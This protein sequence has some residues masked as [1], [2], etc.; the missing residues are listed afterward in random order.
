[1]MN[2]TEWL[3]LPLL[4]R[5]WRVLTCNHIKFFEDHIRVG[6]VV[7]KETT[8]HLRDRNEINSSWIVVIHVI[9][10]SHY[11]RYYCDLGFRS[12]KGR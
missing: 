1:M 3:E 9:K 8:L 12:G 7:D 5:I 10:C 2:K 11:N 6:T 4:T